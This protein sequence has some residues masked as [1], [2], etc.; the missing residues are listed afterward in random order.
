M[1]SENQSDYGF[2]DF[3]EDVVWNWL[4]ATVVIMYVAKLQ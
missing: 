4:I 3:L 1:T 2:K